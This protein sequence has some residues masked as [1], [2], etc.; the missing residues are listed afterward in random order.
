MDKALY[1]QV[2]AVFTEACGLVPYELPAFLDRACAGQPEVRAEV[3]SL[4][5]HVREDDVFEAAAPG[6]DPLRVLGVVIDKRYR[7]DAYVTSGG[8]SHVY[9]GWH[10][11]WNLPIAL[12]FFR[13][14]FPTD[15]ATLGEAF[16]REGALLARLS[17]QTTAV[18]Q[19]FDLGVWTAPRGHGITYT[20]LEWLDGTTLGEALAADRR[21]WPLEEVLDTLGPIA[22]ALGL[23]HGAGIAH[24]DVKP[25]NIFVQADG[26]GLKLLDFGTAKLAAHYSRGFEGTSSSVTPF[27]V[28]YAAPEQAAAQ[29]NA[30]GPRTDVYA[31][32]LICVEMLAG[33]PPY[34]H[35]TTRAVLA[36]ALDPKRR[37]TPRS[38]GV[39]LTV[40]VESVF[41]QALAIS[42][43]ARPADAA[44]LWTALEAAH[45]RKRRWFGR[46]R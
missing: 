16:V 6:D 22:A 21:Q 37:P 25:A 20:A 34:T 18:V 42:P 5:S 44:A 19:S 2:H 46:W 8:F 41:Q 23:A 35:A 4:L 15:S 38:L 26:S 12:K 43:D 39:K 7:V 31:L 3:E 30:T 40:P 32:A 24:R 1:E 45:R 17:R 14:N 10:L 36:Q 28:N 13:E 27:T 9:R 29:G 11:A 33:R